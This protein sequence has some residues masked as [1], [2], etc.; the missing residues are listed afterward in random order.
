MT[1]NELGVQ[2]SGRSCYQPSADII[3][4]ASSPQ[5]HLFLPNKKEHPSHPPS[6]VYRT[7]LIELLIGELPDFVVKNLHIPTG[8]IDLDIFL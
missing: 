4:T 8:S 7:G 5:T 3:I 2:R 1:N 6:T